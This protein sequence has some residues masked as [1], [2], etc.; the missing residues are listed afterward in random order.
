MNYLLSKKKD[1][2][3]MNYLLSKKKDHPWTINKPSTVLRP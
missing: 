2:P 3:C 1:H